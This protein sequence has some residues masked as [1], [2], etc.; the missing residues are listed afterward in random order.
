[1]KTKTGVGEKFIFE[2]FRTKAF[3]KHFYPE[4]A[5]FPRSGFIES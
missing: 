4:R 5:K 1:M 2:S 3:C